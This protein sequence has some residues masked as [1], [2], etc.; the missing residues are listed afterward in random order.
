M[1]SEKEFISLI[2]GQESS[3]LDFKQKMYDFSDKDKATSD[4][5]KDVICMS[6]TIRQSNSYIII[7]I[8]EKK[9]GEKIIHGLDDDIDDAI[10]QDKVKNKVFPRPIFSFYKLNYKN[11]KFGIIEFPITKYST[12]LTPTV[13]LRGLEIGKV[14]YRQGTSNTEALV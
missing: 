3:I 2:E 4:F 6:N 5:V 11:T 9:N 8:E 14:Y 10:L 12:P 7:G 1:L 13:K